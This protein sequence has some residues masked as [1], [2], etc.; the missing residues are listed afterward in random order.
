MSKKGQ[1]IFIWLLI[2]IGLGAIVLG[3]YAAVAKPAVVIGDLVIPVSSAD[4]R[5][6]NENAKVTLVEYSDFQCPACKYYYGI[7]K[8]LEKE[9]GDA[10]Q[11]VYRHFP[12]QQHAFAKTAAIA[13]EAA[14]K[15]GK[16][17][18]M[19]DILFDR[20]E[21]WSVSENIQQS[22][23]EYAT[24][25]GLD[26]PKF[27]SDVQSVDLASRVERAITEGGTQ[28]IQGTPTFFIN[29]TQVRF[30]SYEELKQ[31]VEDELNK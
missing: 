2:V 21:E 3:M 6:G 30:Q 8:E 14:G 25:I 9:K 13:T 16:F 7:V 27:I 19:H 1:E 28:G 11:M 23:V 29:G 12:L 31:L 10:V 26:I 18:E 17:W 15:Q 22:I 5:K 20:Q 24:L 4:W